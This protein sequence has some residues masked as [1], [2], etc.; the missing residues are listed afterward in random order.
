MYHCTLLARDKEMVWVE[1]G[2]V[3]RWEEGLQ[4]DYAVNLKHKEA[5]DLAMKIINDPGKVSDYSSEVENVSIKDD[6]SKDEKLFDENINLTNIKD[7]EFA[8]DEDR[9]LFV[10]DLPPE[11]TADVLQGYF[12]TFGGIEEVKRKREGKPCGHGFILF[13][14]ISSVKKASDKGEHLIMEK[15]IRIGKVKKGKGIKRPIEEKRE[16]SSDINEGAGSGE[17]IWKRRKFGIEK[18]HRIS[19]VQR[20]DPVIIEDQSRYSYPHCPG[21]KRSTGFDD[22]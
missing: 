19:Y 20:P 8:T 16:N 2:D 14:G 3:K 7:E 5:I 21:P 10:G 12:G 18:G 4:M 1:E 11:V 9:T 13:K 6:I 17:K 22:D 15:I